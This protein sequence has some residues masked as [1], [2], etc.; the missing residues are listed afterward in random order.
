MKKYQNILCAIDLSVHSRATAERAAD[1]ARQCG[2]A[3]TFLHVVEY[4]PEDR[5]NQLIAPEDIDPK[6]YRRQEDMTA[7]AQLANDV[8]YPQGR[9]EVVFTE[10]SARH[11]ITWY[12][13]Q[14]NVDLVVI[15]THGMHGASDILG[16]TAYG[17]MHTA[18]CDVLAVRVQA[19]AD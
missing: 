11:V 19:T 3:L 9:H 10:G 16:A 5:S 1:M 8:G 7:L 6:V 13:K 17:V 12:A 14:H 15:G 4:F 2:A 18:P